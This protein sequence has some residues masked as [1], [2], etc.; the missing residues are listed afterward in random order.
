MWQY[1]LSSSKQIKEIEISRVE[2][3]I[4]LANYYKDNI[5]EKYSFVK[6]VFDYC[7]ITKMLEAKRQT[8]EIK[9]FDQVE[10]H[11]IYSQEEINK[12]EKL[13]ENKDFI[14]AIIKMSSMH[15][16]EVKGCFKDWK[17]SEN[18]NNPVVTVSANPKEVYCDFFKTYVMETLNNAEYFAMSF[19][20]NTADESVIYQS[21]YPSYLEMCFIL[22]YFIARHSNPATSKLF[23]NVADLYCSWRDKQLKQNKMYQDNIRKGSKDSGT[24]V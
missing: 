18:S 17:N 7:G 8:V 6:S 16:V 11:V 9:E 23:T 15:N 21:I 14:D 3:A 12:L 10:L 2:K 22:Y 13:Y 1:Y 24:I 20:H 4:E 19:T 5:L